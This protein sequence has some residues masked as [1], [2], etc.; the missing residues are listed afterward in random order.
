MVYTSYVIPIRSRMCD[1]AC[2][3]REWLPDSR[4]T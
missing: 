3:A 4:A 2:R 1:H